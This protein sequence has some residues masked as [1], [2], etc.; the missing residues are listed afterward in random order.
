MI[1]KSIEE[2]EKKMRKKWWIFLIIILAII[3]LVGIL[4]VIPK[5][6]SELKEGKTKIVTSFYPIYIMTLNLTQGA[7][8]IE[9]TNLAQNDVGCLHDYTLSTAD[10]K[11]IENADILI[12]NGLG[13]EN[14]IDKI[15]E[16]YSNLKIINS[17]EEIINK[18][19]EGDKVNPHIWT[20]IENYTKQIEVIT[21]KLCEYN[22]ENAQIYQAN[23]QK[24]LKTL[25]DLK[26]EYNTKLQKLNG[27]KVICLNET[28]TYL[29]RDLQMQVTSVETNHEEST[30]SA[31]TVKNIIEKMKQENI[32]IIFVGS[33]DDLKNAQTLAAETGAKI[34]SLETA[35]VGEV[36]KD[37]YI[38]K[39]TENLEVLKQ[40]ENR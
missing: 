4:L 33:E 11:K 23:Y 40:I 9:I 16:A 15:I 32:K 18:I 5:K 25:N 39:M 24:Y 19:Q 36:N 20:S 31:D 30:L 22:P 28:L 38:T 10:M 35:M 3:A 12:Q 34:Y 14:F 27:S 2:R 37:A 26:L 17:G 13:L 1:K 7:Q 6:K 8:N 29:A 21:Q